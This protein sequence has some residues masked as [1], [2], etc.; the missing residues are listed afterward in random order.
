MG[1]FLEG[2]MKRIHFE[3]ENVVIR[4]EIVDLPQ[5]Q[6]AFV[7]KLKRAYFNTENENLEDIEGKNVYSR[8]LEIEGLGADL[9][10]KNLL[11]KTMTDAKI[12]SL[13]VKEF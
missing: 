4:F 8:N 9:E 5:M 3:I 1:M 6:S 11:L 10:R 13:S 12:S 2:L 7:L